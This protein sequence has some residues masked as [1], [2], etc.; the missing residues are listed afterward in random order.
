MNP[1]VGGIMFFDGTT[2][3][4]PNSLD[5][6]NHVP[7]GNGNYLNN[8][9]TPPCNADVAMA[10]GY[11][12][13]LAAGEEAVITLNASTTNPGG[14][15]LIQSHPQDPNNPSQVDLF[16][17]GGIVIQPISVS[18]VPEPGYWP[19]LGIA[20]AAIAGIQLRR[21]ALLRKAV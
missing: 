9:S 18:G 7:V 10:L 12:F 19:V 17:H 21:K 6:T 16:L 1:N 14:F 13:S 4:F 2:E 3:S 5:N 15:Y 8:C 11:S 20:L